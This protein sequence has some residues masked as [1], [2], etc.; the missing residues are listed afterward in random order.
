MT[1]K[2]INLF[3]EPAIRVGSQ[4]KHLE[5]LTYERLAVVCSLFLFTMYYMVRNLTRHTTAYVNMLQFFPK[6]IYIYYLYIFPN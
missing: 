5:F 3:R 2:K 6:D 4:Q 1:E